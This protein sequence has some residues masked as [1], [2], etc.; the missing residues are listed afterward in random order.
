MK[1]MKHIKFYLILFAVLLLSP[2][3]ATAQ[4]VEKPT[5]S[6]TGNP[7]TIEIGGISVEGV[8]NYED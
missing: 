7:R 2:L 3:A 5:I 6:Y 8:K 1:K 4:V